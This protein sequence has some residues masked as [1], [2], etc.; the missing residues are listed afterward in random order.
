MEKNAQ[1]EANGIQ[2]ALKE[3]RNEQSSQS[4]SSMFAEVTNHLKTSA[5][6]VAKGNASATE[7]LEMGA[8][9]VGT[10]ALAK[11][12]F[13]ALAGRGAGAMAAGTRES[14]LLAKG[15]SDFVVEEFSATGEKM[16]TSRPM[17][18]AA[19]ELDAL[20][21]KGGEINWR[22]RPG[23]AAEYEVTLPAKGANGGKLAADELPPESF[24]F[25]SKY[26]NDAKLAN[27]VPQLKGM[28]AGSLELDLRGSKLSDAGLRP[29]VD[30]KDNLQRLD[31]RNTGVSR[32]AVEVLRDKLPYTQLL[33]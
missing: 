31:L 13:S 24:S 1:T 18:A 14:G 8:L 7:Y 17:N 2:S 4:D 3:A 10:V 5:T 28:R 21:A 25:A 20:R 26:L 27:L 12:G 9:A 6:N 32:Q 22:A 29:L 23:E 19:R 11:V 16:F 15:K 30:V 33:F